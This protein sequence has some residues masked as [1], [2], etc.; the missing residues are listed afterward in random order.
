MSNVECQIIQIVIV[1]CQIIQILIQ[2]LCGMSNVKC[3]MWNVECQIIIQISK[4]FCEMWVKIW[5]EMWNVNQMWK[6]SKEVCDSNVDMWNIKLL[7]EYKY[8]N[9]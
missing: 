3:E 6:F 7:F 8:I 5:I 1:K 9:L 2:I 4:E